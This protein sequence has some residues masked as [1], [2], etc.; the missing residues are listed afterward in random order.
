[1]RDLSTQ[2]VESVR[3]PPSPHGKESL[4]NIDFINVLYLVWGQAT[5]YHFRL[6]GKKLQLGPSMAVVGEQLLRPAG[7]VITVS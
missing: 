6:Q 4:G 1:M 5:Q 2:T 7:T 3:T